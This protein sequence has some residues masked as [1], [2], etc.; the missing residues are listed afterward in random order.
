MMIAP[1]FAT[2]S[3]IIPKMQSLFWSNKINAKENVNK[4]HWIEADNFVCSIL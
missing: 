3:A 1:F 4:L 2:M